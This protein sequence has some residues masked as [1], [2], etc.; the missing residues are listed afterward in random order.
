MNAGERGFL[1]L[2]SQLGNPERKSLTVA[3][4]RVLADRTGQM[5]ETGQDR[6]LSADDL[7]AL[8]YDRAMAS[9]IVALLEDEELLDRYLDRGNHQDCFSITRVNPD[10][11]L[12]VRQRLGLNAPG[13]LWGKGDISL[14]QTQKIAL[15]GSREVKEPNRN[16]A[17]QV[18]FEAARQGITLVSGNARGADRLAQEACL[19]HG[20]NVISVVADELQKHPL[21]KHVLYLSEDSFDQPF[22]AQRALSR[23]RVIHTL[24]SMVIVAQCD[25]GAGG[26]WDGTTKNLQHSWCPVFCFDDR[27]QGAEELEQ[28]GA[29]RISPEQLSDFPSLQCKFQSL[30]E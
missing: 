14:L 22:S 5:K 3:Q 17:M 15:V 27:S 24:G 25:L 19:E 26:T 28:M 11:P 12:A 21:K 18:G 4:F 29:T 8:G 2:T 16:F 20:G 1:M 9:R 7:V 23:N 10:Y 30:F 6:E 13:C